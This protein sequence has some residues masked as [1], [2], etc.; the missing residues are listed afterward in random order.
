MVVE[1]GRIQWVGPAARRKVPADAIVEDLA[2]KFVMPGIINL[3]CHLGNTKG[4]TQDPKNFTRENVEDHLRTC[5]RFGVTSVVTM[6][7]EQELILTLRAEQRR[8]GRPR[9]ARIYAARRGFTGI[10]G[11]P[12]SAPGMKGVPFEVASAEDV[13]R[14]V[15]CLAD[16]QPDMVKIWVDDHLGKEKKISLD[17]CKEIVG[18]AKAGN[19]KVAAHVFYLE[20]AKR[21][22]EY[23]LDG[24]AHSIRDRPVDR[25]LIELMKKRAAWL[26]SATLAREASTFF[27]AKAQPFYEDPFFQKAVAP[28]VLRTLRDPAYQRRA[29]AEPDTGHGPEWLAMAKKNLKAMVDAGVKVGFGTDTG[30]P[31]RFFGFG[32]HWEMELMAEAGLT[33]L[34]IL[35][36]ATGKSAE[37]LGA[38]DLGV[39]AAGKWADLIVL[40]RNPLD[41]IRNTRTIAAVWIAGNKVN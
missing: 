16:V 21:L 39:L 6:G 10:G 31:R 30:P 37:F 36:I 19:L 5:A 23:G 41:D 2:G 1:E 24:L 22:R 18:Q 40:A 7:R 13:R 17:L 25:E 9:M 32:E 34:Q 27:A 29:A 35:T 33:P 26:S 3:H 28:E 12:T 38:P 4:L 15:S 8:D 20:D 11:Y 14:A